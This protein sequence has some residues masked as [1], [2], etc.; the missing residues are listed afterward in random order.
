MHGIK[1]LDGQELP[2][3]PLGRDT[4]GMIEMAKQGIWPSFAPIGYRNIMG[5][6]GNVPSSQTRTPRP[7]SPACSTGLLMAT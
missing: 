2:G 6:D 1:V 5:P 7:S 4:E 3:Q